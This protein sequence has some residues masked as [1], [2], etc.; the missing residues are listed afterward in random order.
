[1]ANGHVVIL[2]ASVLAFFA[3][4]TLSDELF[5]QADTVF[6]SGACNSSSSSPNRT[7]CAYTVETMGYT[8]QACGGHTL[9]TPST[10]CDPVLPH[11]RS[12]VLVCTRQLPSTRQLNCQHEI[13]FCFC[14]LKTILVRLQIRRFPLGL[15]VCILVCLSI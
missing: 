8:L 10:S 15:R 14:R 11:V 1:M 4:N 5:I 6:N 7:S 3:V 2:A 9:R 12:T 13:C